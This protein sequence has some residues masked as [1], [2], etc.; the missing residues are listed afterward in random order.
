MSFSTVAKSVDGTTLLHPL[1]AVE[2]DDDVEMVQCSNSDLISSRVE[3]EYLSVAFESRFFRLVTLRV[4][5]RDD[6]RSASSSCR[7]EKC[8][9]A[10]ADS[11]LG[12]RE[13]SSAA[14]RFEVSVAV[15]QEAVL[16]K[17]SSDGCK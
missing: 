2:A 6:L 11:R 5:D 7:I 4:L 14:N 16:A 12:R 15:A 13:D 17:T 9:E 10:M 1:G 8:V 3:W